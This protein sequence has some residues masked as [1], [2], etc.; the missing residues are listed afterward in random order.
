MGLLYGRPGRL[1]AQ[2]GGFRPVQ[3]LSA[4]KVSQ[5]TAAA[6]ELGAPAA[7]VDAAVGAGLARI[8]V[9]LCYHSPTSHQICEEIWRLYFCF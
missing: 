1:T 2:N 5:L 3:W 7:A 9:P 6:R 8:A 4:Q